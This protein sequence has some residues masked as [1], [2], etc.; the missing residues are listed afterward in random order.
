MKGVFASNW[1]KKMYHEGLKMD[2]KV[3]KVVILDQK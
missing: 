1:D 2:F 3:L